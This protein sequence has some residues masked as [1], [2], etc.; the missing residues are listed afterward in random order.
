MKLIFLFRNFLFI[1][2]KASHRPFE[3]SGLFGATQSS[4]QTKRLLQNLTRRQKYITL[5]SI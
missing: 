2:G 3:H 4:Q 5:K 1:I